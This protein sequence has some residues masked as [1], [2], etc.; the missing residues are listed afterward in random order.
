MSVAQGPSPDTKTVSSLEVKKKNE[1]LPCDKEEEIFIK[2]TVV[3][4]AQGSVDLMYLV[5]DF[6]VDLYNET[7]N[8]KIVGARSKILHVCAI[9]L[10]TWMM[11][12]HVLPLFKNEAKIFRMGGFHLVLMTLFSN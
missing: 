2:Y 8:F 3:A 6:G 10:A 9:C 12:C 7:K 1:K 5:S 11:C 4:E